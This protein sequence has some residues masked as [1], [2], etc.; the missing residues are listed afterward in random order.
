MGDCD[1]ARREACSKWTSEIERRETT[2]STVYTD[3]ATL[4]F[5]TDEEAW[6]IF[7]E[8]A[9]RYLGVTVA[10][11]LEK[12]DAGRIPRCSA[13]GTSFH[14]ASAASVARQDLASSHIPTG[15]ITWTE[16]NSLLCEFTS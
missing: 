15:E 12:W 4:H 13:I 6:E 1:S 14:L 8:A 9:E 2:T 16:L 3:L 7:N 5:L 10:R 11:F